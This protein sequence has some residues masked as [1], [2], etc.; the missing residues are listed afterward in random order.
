[1]GSKRSSQLTSSLP[2][3]L[4][5]LHLSLAFFVH[6]R[7]Y[8]LVEFQAIVKGK[9]E[10]VGEEVERVH[11]A[12]KWKEIDAGGTV[13]EVK[14]SIGGLVDVLCSREGGGGKAKLWT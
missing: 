13:E 2:P 7:R 5:F 3:P 10:W 14:E 9:F 4:T 6:F 1:L 11:G 8:E 12:G